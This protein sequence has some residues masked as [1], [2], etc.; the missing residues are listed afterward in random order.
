MPAHRPSARLCLFLP[1][2]ALLGPGCAFFASLDKSNE[3]RTARYEGDECKGFELEE[4]TAYVNENGAEQRIVTYRSPQPARVD[5]VPLRVAKVACGDTIA[6][7]PSDGGASAYVQYHHDF[8]ARRFDHTTA[9]LI[10][11]MC[12]KDS[13]CIGPAGPHS[14]RDPEYSHY[15][16]GQLAF[17]AER[18]DPAAVERELKA[19]GIS[20]GLRAHFLAELAK[21]RA[22]VKRIVAEIPKVAAEVLVDIP[23]A[24]R[25]ERAAEDAR[26]AELYARFDG[27]AAK[28]K[29]LRETGPD[30]ATITA[31][32]DLRAEWVKA[33]GD[34]A[35]VDR[36]L[37]VLIARELFFA[38][39]ARQDALGAQVERKLADPET[40]IEAALEID[41]RQREAMGSASE[42][43]RKQAA[44]RDQGL[45]ESTTRAAT[46]GAQAY[47]FSGVRRWDFERVRRVQWAQLVPGGG[48]PYSH[49]GKLRAKKQ[50]GTSTVLEF[51]DIV[52][53]YAD[54]A[55]RE[56]NRV[57]RIESDG[58]LVYGQK[59]RAT[60]KTNVYRRKIDPIIVP[61]REA[62]ALEIGD[63]VIALVG[64]GEP[65]P[66][67]IVS[68]VRK[69]VVVQ[70]RD[71]RQR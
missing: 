34:L 68:A 23:L 7:Y 28:A 38:H 16:A 39:V 8:D 69:D 71:V 17:Y 2:V 65:K 60:G 33:C 11:T 13:S 37:G 5:A 50:K 40:P 47:D 70:R 57:E 27:A 53:R 46:A 29:S 43:H 20:E 12:N 59:C 48:E 32:E 22:E 63:E 30:D 6:S 66:A 21:A 64:P 14:K 18:V 54:E 3:T 1:L 62:K 26:H 45:D 52:D 4:D 58:R 15:A 51:A 44:L 67:R 61:A 19:A 56:T 10:L 36:G 55:C 24:V 9:A 42:T 41:R 49:G 31:L 35:C 25:K